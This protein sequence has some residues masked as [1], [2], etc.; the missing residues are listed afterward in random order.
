MTDETPVSRP[1]RRRFIDVGGALG[2]PRVGLDPRAHLSWQTARVLLNGEAANREPL[3]DAW[4]I[5]FAG[6]QP[7]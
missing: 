2:R 6:A 7:L 5:E 4:R 3:V 1:A